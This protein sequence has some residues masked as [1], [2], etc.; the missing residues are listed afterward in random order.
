MRNGFFRRGLPRRSS[1]PD[2]RLCP[3]AP[4][5][6]GQG[7]QRDKRVVHWHQPRSIGV[8]SELVSTDNRSHSAFH[9]CLSYEV[10]AV[11]AFTLHGKKKLS[12]LN[13]ARVDGISLRY[14]VGIKLTSG[15]EKF[16]NARE[17]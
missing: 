13:G 9:Q 10:V 14:R 6:R 15:G 11:H 8:A 2:Q 3:Q 16:G 5:S 12:G 4:N 1:Y 17:R 7:L